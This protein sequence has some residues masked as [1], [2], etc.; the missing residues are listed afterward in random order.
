MLIPKGF[1]PLEIPIA[2]ANI[3]LASFK[4]DTSII[5]IDTTDPAAIVTTLTT[6]NK[7]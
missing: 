7:K 1:I 4:E 2:P 3:L 5:T 6:N